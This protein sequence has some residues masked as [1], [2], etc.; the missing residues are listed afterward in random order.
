MARS[1]LALIAA[2]ALLGCGDETEGPSPALRAD[3]RVLHQIIAN[4]PATEPLELVDRRIDDE[5]PVHAA[6]LLRTTGIP[7]AER[8]VA[9]LRSAQM[10]SDE[11]RGFARR[12]TE[13]YQERVDALDAYRIVLEG[14][15]QVDEV[16]LLDALRRVRQAQEQLLGIAR[17]MN[18]LT[19]G[20]RTPP[21]PGG[22]DP[23]PEAPGDE[24]GGAG[25]SR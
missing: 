15:A 11:G 12:L 14:G 7:A 17:E 25:G 16:A 2:L 1:S 19:P 3:L 21:P 10:T 22:P 23:E 18:A 8:Q 13:A 6:D 20:V 5:R 4:D 24:A 9:S